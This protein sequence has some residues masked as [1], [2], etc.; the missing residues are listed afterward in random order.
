MSG[1]LGKLGTVPMQL[2]VVCSIATFYIVYRL[3]TESSI[4]AYTF[5]ATECKIMAA[6]PADVVFTSYAVVNS[7]WISSSNNCSTIG[8]HFKSEKIVMEKKYLLMVKIHS[9]CRILKQ[10]LHLCMPHKFQNI[11]TEHSTSDVAFHS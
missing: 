4:C 9:N 7:G 2:V 8:G 11:I 10:K 1:F 6:L 3:D 5:V